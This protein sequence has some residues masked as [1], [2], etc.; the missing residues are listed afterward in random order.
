MADYMYYLRIFLGTVYFEMNSELLSAA[1]YKDRDNCLVVVK[2][3]FSA[4]ASPGRSLKE[5]R[6]C[7]PSLPG[8]FKRLATTP[9]TLIK[10]MDAVIKKAFLFIAFLLLYHHYSSVMICCCSL[11]MSE[12][13]PRARRK[14]YN[15][16]GSGLR[17]IKAAVA[18]FANSRSR[19]DE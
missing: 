11:M 19:S 1:V 12:E 4:V 13:K 9:P 14:R 7:A 15:L 16:T 18:S 10:R 8:R 3:L 6:T 5:I 17:R 2:G